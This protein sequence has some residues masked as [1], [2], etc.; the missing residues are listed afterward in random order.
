MVWRFDVER[1]GSSMVAGR[2]IVQSSTTQLMV[3]IILDLWCASF[4][5]GLSIG[6]QCGVVWPGLV[7]SDLAIGRDIAAGGSGGGGVL[8]PLESICN[9]SCICQP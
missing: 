2:M 9:T 1:V 6:S 4:T 5:S 8:A 7:W 3:W